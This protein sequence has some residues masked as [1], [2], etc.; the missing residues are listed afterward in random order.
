M[1]S[2]GRGSGQVVVCPRSIENILGEYKMAN[3]VEFKTKIKQGI[4]EIPEEYKQELREEQEVTVIVVKP[5]KRIPQTGM[6]AEL[7]QNPIS[8]PGIRQLTRDEIHSL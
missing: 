4:I 1:D 3:S 5:P 8:I 6:I 7:T 2:S